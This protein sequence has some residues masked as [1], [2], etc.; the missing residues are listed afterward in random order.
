[1]KFGKFKTPTGNAGSI[2]SLGDLSEM[3][4]GA[5]VLL[6]TFAMGQWLFQGFNRVAPGPLRNEIEPVMAQPSAPTDSLR[7]I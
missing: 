6:F 1:M 2:F 5:F 4:L 3:I 7:V